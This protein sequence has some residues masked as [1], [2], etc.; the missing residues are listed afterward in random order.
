VSQNR[1]LKALGVSKGMIYYEKKGY[2]EKRRARILQDEKAIN[3]IK[4]VA[5]MRPTYGCPRLRAIA[6]RD[7]GLNL[8]AYKVYRISKQQGL[9]IKPSGSRKPSREHTG[10]VMVEKPNTRW[11]SDI[12]E[13]RLWD[14]SRLRFTYIL[15]CCDRSVIAWR[16]SSRIWAVDIELMMQEALLSRF[17]AVRAANDLEFLHDNGP[18]YIEK[19]FQESLK[20]WNV[21]DC[22]TP[23][24]SPQSN[25]ICES[26]NGTFKRDYVYQNCLETEAEVRQM[27]AD[28]IKDYNT[29]A[30][31]SALGMQTPTEYFKLQ[32]A[33]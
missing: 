30:P 25:G 15:D 5:I 13:I 3:V 29:F 21:K 23:T 31:H 27:I 19:Q 20:S 2:P 17:G 9:L 28:S 33:A 22:R 8:T 11:A 12:T 16:L 24:Y 18:E 6:K 14:R 4:E 10:K 7:Y 26:F 1:V 32:M